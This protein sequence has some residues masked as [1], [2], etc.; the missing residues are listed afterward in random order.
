MRVAFTPR[1][2]AVALAVAL[3]TS[4][5]LGQ[6]GKPTGKSLPPKP[7]APASTP[8]HAVPFKVGEV[9]T[10]EV[11]WSSLLVG[12]TA[13]LT[14]KDRRTSAGR[15]GYYITAEG[16]PRPFLQKLYPF[17]YRADSLLD[18][19]TLLPI[20]ASTFSEERGRTQ[21]KI[22]RFPAT[23]TTIDYEIR[24]ATVVHEKRQVP[25]YVQ[26]PLSVLYFL[27]GVTFQPGDTI[28]IP[29]TD[30][31]VL[32]YARVVFGSPSAIRTG[33][34][35]FSAWQVQLTVLDE[36]NQETGQKLT[37]WLSSDARRLPVRF[38]VG[39]PVGTFVVTL[40]HVGP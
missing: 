36:Q 27:R 38:D 23:G 31:G 12:G 32:Y 15:A 8:D 3:S 20:Q 40:T 6:T 35:V 22:T 9:L 5:A 4:A 21:L 7:S 18:V 33:A 30:G 2:Y 39:L 16:G 19:K 26:D 11:S 1:L 14:V 29:V 13:E 37:I 17:Q 28:K 10:Y 24:T 25:P 34:G